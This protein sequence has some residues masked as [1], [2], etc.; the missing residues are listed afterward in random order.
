MKNIKLSLFILLLSFQTVT[1]ADEAKVKSFKNG[2]QL[3]ELCNADEASFKEGEC[4]G[5]IMAIVDNNESIVT[6]GL[7]QK[8]YCIPDDLIVNQ[9]LR[10]VVKYLQ[11]NPEKLHMAASDLLTNAFIKTF[12]C[13]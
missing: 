7:M 1:Y 10:V 12:P 4:F 9:L 3:L 5:Y 11:E 2:N 8:L 6:A 13:Q